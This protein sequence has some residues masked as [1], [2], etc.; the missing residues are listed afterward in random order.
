MEASAQELAAIEAKMKKIQLE[1][2]HEQ[3][4]L[5]KKE[6]E[7]ERIR[8]KITS[9]EHEEEGLRTDYD[10]VHRELGRKLH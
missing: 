1:I 9:L 5:K 7:A 2:Q 6:E 10:K 8:E 4:E 3:P